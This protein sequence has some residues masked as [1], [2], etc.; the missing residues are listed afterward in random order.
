MGVGEQLVPFPELFTYVNSV[1]V[2]PKQ[3]LC[4]I[5]ESSSWEIYRHKARGYNSR[6]LIESDRLISGSPLS[7]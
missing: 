2:A 4:P 7:Q 1:E 3:S 5:Q 6:S